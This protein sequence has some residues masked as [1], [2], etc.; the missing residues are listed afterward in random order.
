MYSYPG[1]RAGFAERD[2]SEDKLKEVDEEFDDEDEI[3]SQ[4]A[5]SRALGCLRRSFGV[6]SHWAVVDIETVW[7]EYWD[8]ILGELENRRENHGSIA[9]PAIDML[10]RHDHNGELGCPVRESYVKCIPTMAGGE[11]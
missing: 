10:T 5:W 7:E 8:R 6:G 11:F 4:L 1:S 3:S 2:I 9:E